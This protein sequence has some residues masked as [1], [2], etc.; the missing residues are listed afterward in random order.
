MYHELIINIPDS[1]FLGYDIIEHPS[2]PPWQGQGDNYKKMRLPRLD[3]LLQSRLV[4]TAEGTFFENLRKSRE[5]P[6]SGSAISHRHIIVS[7]QICE[8]DS[9]TDET[10]I[11]M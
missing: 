2:A 9:G 3:C 11:F 1:R 8:A 10:I 4:V 7:S 5:E 6:F